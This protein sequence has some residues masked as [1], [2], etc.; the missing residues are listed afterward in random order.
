MYLASEIPQFSPFCSAF[1]DSH[2]FFLNSYQFTQ[3]GVQ[4]VLKSQIYTLLL[5]RKEIKC[6]HMGSNLKVDQLSCS[7]VKSIVLNF[8]LGNNLT[9]QENKIHFQNIVSSTT[10]Q[11]F[12]G[13]YIFWETGGSCM[14]KKK[15]RYLPEWV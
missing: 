12:M 5:S 3:K 8:F 15:G 11:R 14:R 2:N 4:K 6:D 13:L 9:N 7:K 1:L 10:G